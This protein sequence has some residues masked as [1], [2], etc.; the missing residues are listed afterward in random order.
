MTSLQLIEQPRLRLKGA[1]VG[2]NRPGRRGSLARGAFPGER[3]L[4]EGVCIR[5]AVSLADLMDALNF[6]RRMRKSMGYPSPPTS[7]LMSDGRGGAREIATFV[8]KSWPEVVAM[9]TLVVDPDDAALPADRVFRG[10]LA[11]LRE[12]GR[13]L[14]EVTNRATVPAYYRTDVPSDLVRCCAAHAMFV[15]STDLVAVL[16]PWQLGPYESLGFERIGRMRTLNGA[17][18]EPVM[19]GRLDLQALSGAPPSLRGFYLRHNPYHRHVRTWATLTRPALQ[20][21]G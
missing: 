4:A 18:P 6:L 13:F 11:E 12:G 14:C 19:L 20:A 9:A 21:A 1:T 2:R 17:V 7:A 8:A 16:R 15:G 5:R 3:Q 10:E